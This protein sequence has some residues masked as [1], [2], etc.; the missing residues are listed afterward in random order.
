MTSSLAVPHRALVAPAPVTG[1]PYLSMDLSRV[2]LAYRRLTSAMPDVQMH[3][4]MKCNPDSTVL[5]HI[6]SLGAGFEVASFTEIGMLLDSG[7]S[8]EHV[9]FSNPVKAERH[10][11]QASA[12]GVWRFAVDSPGE[13]AKVATHAPGAAVYLR[14]ACDVGSSEVHSE[15]KFGVD[16]EAA[17]HLLRQAHHLDLRIWGMAF[18]VGSQM[19]DPAAWDD[20]IATC[21]ALMARLAADNIFASMVNVGGGF[22]VSYGA[23]VPSINEFGQRILR[24]LQRHMPYETEV[25]AEPGRA[26]VAEA[27]V[28]VATV[29]GIAERQERA[30]YTSMW[31]HLTA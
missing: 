17:Y 19:L 22:P 13:L 26:L 25:V 24:C 7:I 4:A 12:A 15:G 9:I 3:Y 10:I 5:R 27:G 31:A 23:P 1:T 11:A 20:P 29:I 18:H 16:P 8:T 30:G 14:L 6:A 21:G 28:L 2:S